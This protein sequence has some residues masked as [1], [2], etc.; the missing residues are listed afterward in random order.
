ML[1]FV[2]TFYLKSRIMF[3][4]FILKPYTMKIKR[5]SDSDNNFLDFEFNK[6]NLN[7]F[8]T[9]KPEKKFLFI[10][11]DL[12]FVS[13]VSQCLKDVNFAFLQVK[14]NTLSFG[15]FNLKLFGEKIFI[16][17]KENLEIKDYQKKEVYLSNENDLI[18]WKIVN[19]KK[20]FN[21]KKIK[22]KF[23]LKLLA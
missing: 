2:L 20:D 16:F 9:G 3:L 10:I 21:I 11:E 4:L 12:G 23:K 14:H 18:L 5:I 8:F 1:V 7:V 19:V 22:H 6:G 13:T 15:N 17:L